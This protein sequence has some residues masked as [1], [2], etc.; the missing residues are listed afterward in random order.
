MIK[1]LSGLA[2]AAV[3]LTAVPAMAD[4]LK[5]WG[6]GSV[7][8]IL[9]QDTGL[10]TT[11]NDANLTTNT[12]V[13]LD[14][15]KTM[16]NVTSRLDIDLGTIAPLSIEQASAIVKHGTHTLTVGRFNSPIGFEAQDAPYRLQTSTGQLFGLRPANLTGFSLSADLNPITV[17]LLFANDWNAT[18]VAGSPRVGLTDNTTGLSASLALGGSSTVALGYLTSNA[19]GG[20]VADGDITNL[21][22]TT[23]M[24][25]N[26]LAAFEYQS[27]DVRTGWGLTGNYTH[28]MHGVTLRYDS[29]ETDGSTND[30]ATGLTLAGS[31]K[32]TEGITSQVEYKTTNTGVKNAADSDW[33]TLQFIVGL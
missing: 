30:P 28:G 7:V 13:E 14:F 20:A 31:C 12:W 24:V 11:D 32:M 19:T 26:L 5:V 4:D 1:N 8:T 15:S 27:G 17:G 18:A 10:A 2:V 29:V 23:K 22:A 6:Y 21:V 3:L 9:S 33:I 16:G 25:P